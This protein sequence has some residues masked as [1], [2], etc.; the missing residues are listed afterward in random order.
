MHQQRIC[1]RDIKPE[2]FLLL[3][4]EP[5]EQN[6]LKLIDFGFSCNLHPEKLMT[7]KLGTPRYSS[8]QV[9]AGS[10]DQSCDCWSCGVLT[11]ILL[12]ARPPFTGKSDADLAQSVRRG[13]YSFSGPEWQG[14]SND[15]K[16]LIRMLLK[17][18]PKDRY[19]AEQA[20]AHRWI[21]AQVPKVIGEAP[22]RPS[23]L[24][25]LR[26]FCAQNRLRQA[27]LQ[28][29]AQQLAEEETEAFRKA[30][31]VLD[32][33]GNGVLTVSELAECLKDLEPDSGSQEMQEI[34]KEV[35]E[36]SNSDDTTI[37]Y[38]DFLAATLDAKQHLQKSACL[39]AFRAFDRD[40][41]GYISKGDLERMLTNN[42]EDVRESAKMVSELLQEVDS[43]GDGVIDFAEFKRMLVGDGHVEAS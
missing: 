17:Y 7:T 34:V 37:G 24:L 31:E 1:H 39:A 16:D 33:D 8:P 27:A 25:D 29:V 28:I 2:N 14:V 38:T 6:K 21:K 20:L 35:T 32:A 23:M 9:L 40:G 13:N 30:F 5:T 36:G 3:T 10:Y 19:T 41:D 11:F 12:G 15:A 43:N 22:L 42:R 18:Q 26:N 4:T